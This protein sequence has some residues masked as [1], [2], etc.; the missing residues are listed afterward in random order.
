MTAREA[1]LALSGGMDG[2]GS[3]STASSTPL[4]PVTPAGCPKTV[5]NCLGSREER[6]LLLQ[7]ESCQGQLAALRE[8]VEARKELDRAREVQ[9]RGLCTD[10][11]F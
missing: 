10:L 1:L 7:L 3:S 9:P 8:E 5:Q 6:R 4:A 2:K 11:L